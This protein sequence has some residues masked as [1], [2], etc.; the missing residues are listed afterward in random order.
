MGGPGRLKR[1]VAQWHLAADTWA[2]DGGAYSNTTHSEAG[3]VSSSGRDGTEVKIS[4]Q[5]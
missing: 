5:N 2:E 4:K 3:S 1:V